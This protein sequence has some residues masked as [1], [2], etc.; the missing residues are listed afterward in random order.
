MVKIVDG[1]KIADKI[2]NQASETVARLKINGKTPRLGVILVGENKASDTYVKKKEQACKKAGVDF[3]IEKFSEDITTADLIKE[4]KDLQDK[5]VLSGLIVQL[6]LPEHIDSKQV[7]NTIDPMIDVDCLTEVNLGKLVSGNFDIIPPT[8]GAILEILEEHDIE[9]KGKNVAIVGAG[10]LVG[11]PLANIL[12]HKEATVTITHEETVGLSEILSSADIVITGVGKN[13]LINATM[14]KPRSVIIDAG[15]CF[16]DDKLC[17]DID[18]DSVKEK[19]SVVTCTPGGVG[20]VTVAK[21][22]ENTVKG[23]NNID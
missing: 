1:N 16:V 8:P 20:P 18:F 9:L 6:P 13:N 14:I 10:A 15:I 17:G 23:I 11:R 2:I 3:V 19:A 21:L 7:L 4:T 12:I 22:I 5:Q